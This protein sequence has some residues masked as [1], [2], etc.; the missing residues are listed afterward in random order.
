MKTALERLIGE[1]VFIRTVTMYYVGRLKEVYEHELV[2]TECSWV[3]DTGRFHNALK[4]GVFSEVEP[5]VSE[6]VIVARGGLIDVC[7][8]GH[9]I[10]TEQK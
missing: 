9:A 4:D 10:P 6:E 2:L 3:A 7:H 1:P 8:W 5:F